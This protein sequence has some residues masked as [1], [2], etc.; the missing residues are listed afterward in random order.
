MMVG[1]V[2]GIENVAVNVQADLELTERTE[3]TERFD[4]TSE[5]AG[6]VV[7]ERTSN[8]TYEGEGTIGDAGVLGPDGAPIAGDGTTGNATAYTRDDAERTFAVN[9][10]VEQI[11]HTPGTVTQL[12]VAVLVDE[13]AVSAEQ[14][15]S[16]EELVTTAAGIDPQR[17]DTV[18]VTAL[19]FDVPAVD[20]E[21]QA[22]ADAVDAAA[23][24]AQMMSMIRTVVIGLVLLV[25][26]FLA[27]R[28]TKKARREVSTPIDIDAL[29]A[30]GVPAGALGAGGDGYGADVVPMDAG[31]NQAL[32]ELSALADRN[33]EDVARVLQS[34]LADERQPT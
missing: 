13:A 16:L 34:W 30:A 28:S 31:S 1:R 3:T 21:A 11:N 7:A 5:D 6:V 27:Y 25:A 29:R 15:A 2:T 18:T 14:I 22:V 24:S 32:D 26:L 4:T 23:A 12:S 8:E 20:D 19:P 9:R 33:P 17:G 10:T